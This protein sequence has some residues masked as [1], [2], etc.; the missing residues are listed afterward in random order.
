MPCMS[1]SPIEVSSSPPLS[2]NRTGTLVD[3]L[4]ESAAT[5]NETT[6]KGR[7]RSPVCSGESPRIVWRYRTR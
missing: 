2:R 3:R 1:S 6:V 7:N 4:P 5:K